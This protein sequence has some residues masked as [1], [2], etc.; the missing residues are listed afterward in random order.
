MTDDLVFGFVSGIL[1]AIGVGATF[2]VL[3]LEHLKHRAQQRYAFI[4]DGMAARSSG[5]K[6]CAMRAR[7]DEESG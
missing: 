2:G 1:V 5:C 6:A 7:F 3:I 4:L